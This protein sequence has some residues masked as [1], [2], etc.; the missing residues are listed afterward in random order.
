MTLDLLQ[1]RNASRFVL[2][3]S[4]LMLCGAMAAAV[5]AA[6]ALAV[7]PQSVGADATQ[8]AATALPAEGTSVP[9]IVRVPTLKDLHA[10]PVAGDFIPPFEFSAAEARQWVLDA[11]YVSVSPLELVHT[12]DGV[13]VYHGTAT[14]QGE[15]YAVMVDSWGNIAGWR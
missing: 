15:D 9:E 5:I 12:A 13:P 2:L 14:A 7:E 10:A 11:G 6:P 3:L 1:W 4:A 8:V